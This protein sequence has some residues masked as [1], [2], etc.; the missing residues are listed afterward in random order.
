MT[1]VAY[2]ETSGNVANYQ[3]HMEKA[4]LYLKKFGI[5]YLKV[6]FVGKIIPDGE[7][8]SGQW[9]VN[10]YR[11]LVETAARHH[12]MLIIHEPII[13]TGLSRTYPNLLACEGLRGQEFNAWSEGNPPDHLTIIP[14]TQNLAGPVDYTPGILEVTLSKYRDKN[15]VHNTLANQL[16]CYITLYSGVQMAAD[17]PENYDKFKDAFQFIKD[18]PVNW[19]KS[20]VIQA[21][22]GDYLIMAKKDRNTSNWYIGGVTD[23]KERSFKIGLDFLEN[24]QKYSAQIYADGKD[25]NWETNPTSYAITQSE[26]ESTD[27]LTITMAPGGGQAIRFVKMANK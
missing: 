26:V 13:P 20:K 11:E 24:G 15:R 3:K 12:I 23:E 17:L 6:G 22:V 18:V 16:A 9:M 25:C 14:F 7:Y 21:S 27:S 8:H 4:M 19:E 10:F 1:L 5:N 2:H